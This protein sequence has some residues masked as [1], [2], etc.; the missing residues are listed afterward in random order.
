MQEKPGTVADGRGIHCGLRGQNGLL[1]RGICFQYTILRE[2]C[3]LLMGILGG[4]FVGNRRAKR[5][6]FRSF[7][8]PDILGLFCLVGGKGIR[9]GIRACTFPRMENGPAAKLQQARLREERR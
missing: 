1:H 2:I 6:G 9:A 4:C 7:G 3:I 8:S 5:L